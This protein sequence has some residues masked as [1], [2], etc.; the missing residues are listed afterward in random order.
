M[1]RNHIFQGLGGLWTFQRRL[2]SQTPAQ[3]LITVTGEARFLPVAADAWLYEET[4]EAV[5][6]GGRHRCSQKYHYRRDALSGRIRV[7]FA[8]GERAGKHFYDLLFDD[9]TRP[10]HHARGQHLCGRDLYEASYAF[11]LADAE[12]GSWFL[13]YHVRGPQKHY[14]SRTYLRRM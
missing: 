5:A 14:T 12:L 4:G 3:S 8:L 2:I 11:H 1:D 6:N 13:T 7:F 9:A 10:I